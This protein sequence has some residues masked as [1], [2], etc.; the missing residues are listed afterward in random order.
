VIVLPGP[1]DALGSAVAQILI[2]RRWRG[3]GDRAGF[4]AMQASDRPIV[5]AMQRPE[6]RAR[7]A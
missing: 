4:T 6:Q 1:G 7:V 5:L 2:A 3:L